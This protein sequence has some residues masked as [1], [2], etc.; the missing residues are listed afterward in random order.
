VRRELL[1]L[2]HAKARKISFNDNGEE[3]EAR[4]LKDKGKRHAQRMGAWLA[5]HDL[6]PDCVL[7]S[8]ANRAHTT[9]EKCYKSV[10]WPADLIE[11]DA[12]IYEA[13]LDDL[14]S[15]LREIPK[16][17]RRVMMVGHNPA[18][19]ELV[20][21]LC[22]NLEPDNDKGGYL[23]T[24]LRIESEWKDLRANCAELIQ[25]VEPNTLPHLFPFPTVD[26]L[27]ERI[28]PA[29]YYR[30]SAVIPFRLQDDELQ[31][32]IISSSEQNHW[33]IPKGI[34]EPGL[35]S[36]ASA[37]NEAFEEAGVD[38]RVLDCLLGTYNYKKWGG[39]CA[40]EVYPLAVTHE[41]D[42]L[43]WEGRHRDRQ[44]VSLTKAVSMVHNV[45]PKPIISRLE[46]ALK[47]LK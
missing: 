42:E 8:P 3:D 43:K 19:E 29:Y 47:D 35:S 27:E 10:G 18:L 22:R 38:G 2:R 21:T 33:V 30:Q 5:R 36:K 16:S 14:F 45:D 17:A 15:V 12:R 31:V 46:D 34:H 13:T 9:A 28:R 40:V 41:V 32:L 20:L 44:R 11:K 1:I 39:A 23:R 4:A 6:R 25:I 7:S 37:A 26:G 24:A